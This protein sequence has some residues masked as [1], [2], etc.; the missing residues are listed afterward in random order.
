MLLETVSVKDIQIG[1]QATD[2]EEAIRKAAKPL[3]EDGAIETTYVEGIIS[4][5]RENGPYFVLSKGFALAHA[6]P[7]LGV[8]RLA[9]NFAT[10]DP[11]VSFG[12][13]ENDP[14]SLI[15]TLAAT[16]ANSHLD[17][18]AEL[19][20]ILV[21]EGRMQKMFHAKSPEEFYELLRM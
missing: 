6:R 10:F 11:P 18:L 1:L 8:N 2:W 12:V 5:V 21:E 3:L 16:D 15:V 14:V 4:S 7:E 17:L 19:A 9:L 13:G 20:G